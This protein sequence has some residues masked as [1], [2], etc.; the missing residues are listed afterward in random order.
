[1]NLHKEEIELINNYIPTLQRYFKDNNNYKYFKSPFV[2]KFVL[3]FVLLNSDDQIISKIID[4][5][6]DKLKKAKKVR[7][8]LEKEH[9]EVLKDFNKGHID[10]DDYNLDCNIRNGR[11]R[12]CILLCGNRR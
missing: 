11:R 3:K 6:N 9:N 2:E 4:K 5:I 10:E 8:K 1:M 7:K 12:I